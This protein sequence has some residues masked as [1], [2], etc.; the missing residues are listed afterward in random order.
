MVRFL[1][2][3]PLRRAPLPPERAAAWTAFLRS[4]EQ[5]DDGRSVLLA[6]LPVGR[7]DPAPIALGTAAVR[8]ALDEVAA[9][10]D[11]WRVP[12]LADEWEACRRAVEDARGRLGTIDRIAATTDELDHVLEEV[13]ELMEDLEPFADAEAAF[14]AR[15]RLPREAGG[16]R[17]RG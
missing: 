5:L 1:G 6:T 7:I 10:I 2:L 4:A 12:E 16:G 3:G 13:R 8:A 11:G 17:A 14:R 9:G 15:W